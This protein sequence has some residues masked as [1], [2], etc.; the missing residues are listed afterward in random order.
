MKVELIF[1]AIVLM[2]GPLL[3]MLPKLWH[4]KIMMAITFIVL[5]W[6][7]P[8]SL[9]IMLLIAV[10]QWLLWSIKSQRFIQPGLLLAT[11]IPLVT[12]VVYKFEHKF[13]N[14]LIP[15]GLSYYAFRQVH[16]A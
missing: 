16:V 4:S 5:C 7:A 2:S 3:W 15:L 13:D 12:L 10:T 11:I 8:V 9:M 6:I 1:I 14:W